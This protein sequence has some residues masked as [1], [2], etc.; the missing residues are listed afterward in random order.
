MW[1]SGL[2]CV[3]VRVNAREPVQRRPAPTGF[4]LDAEGS[5]RYVSH[6]TVKSSES[7]HDSNSTHSPDADATPRLP[8]IDNFRDAA[9]SGLGYEV[10]GGRIRRGVLYRSNRLEPSPADLAILES[11]GLTAIHDLR[12]EN[13]V[14][15]YPDSPVDGAAWHHHPVKGLPSETVERLS[16]AAQMYDAMIENYQRYVEDPGC[17]NAFGSFLRTLAD[18]DGPQLVHCAAGKDRTGWAVILVQHIAGL[19]QDRMIDDYFLTDEYA[20][21]SQKATLDSILEDHGQGYAD[22]YR[23]AFVCDTDYLEA[24]FGAVEIVYGSMDDY[25]TDGLGI[26]ATQRGAIRARLVE[27]SATR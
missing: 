3:F 20:T 15:K 21:T 9:G 27:P 26:S 1:W 4:D 13:E 8:S 17:R 7:L 12:N 25:L 6:M 10:P 24:A 14:E 22:A 16:D 2:Q 5:D 19:D 11:L 23:P 18:T